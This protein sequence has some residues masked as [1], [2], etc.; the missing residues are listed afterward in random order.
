MIGDMLRHFQFAAVLEVGSDAGRAESMIANLRL[1]AGGL[2]TA[3][4]HRDRGPRPG[5]R[6]R[7]SAGFR[8][9]PLIA[10]YDGAR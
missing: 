4:D 1:D 2:G 9:C 5:I 6:A 8:A 7:L 10:V 3:L